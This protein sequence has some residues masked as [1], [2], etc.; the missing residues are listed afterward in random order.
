MTKQIMKKLLYLLLFL[1][2]FLFL[3]AFGSSGS[4]P[5]YENRKIVDLPHCGMIPDKNLA[6]DFIFMKNGSLLIGGEYSF[7]RFINAG[8]SLGANNVIGSDDIVFH[9]LPGFN[10]KLRIL[11]ETFKLPA[12]AFGFSNQGYS[13]YI[14]QLDRFQ[15]NS[16]GLFLVLSKSFRWNLGYLASHLGINYSFDNESSDRSPNVYFG[17]EQSLSSTISIN[18]EYNLQ[19]DEANSKLYDKKGML[20]LSLRAAIINGL[21]LDFQLK[22]IL[23]NYKENNSIQRQIAFE[24]IKKLSF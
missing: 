18:I 24:I 9:N 4:N 14:E 20:N 3:G 1:N 2:N 22:D 17:L 12:L 7:L 8:I 21:T 5:S 19:L 23:L 6:I 11:D 13:S 15:V 16:P 10:I